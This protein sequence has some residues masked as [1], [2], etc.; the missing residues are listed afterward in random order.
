MASKKYVRNFLRWQL[1]LLLLMALLAYTLV[2]RSW[3]FSS[4]A[5][6]L[7]IVSVLLVLL[8][9]M[10]QTNLMLASFFG[11]VSSKDFSARLANNSNGLGFDELRAS[12]NK[13]NTE[14]HEMNEV[15]IK[16]K[17][18]FANVL[19]YL[20]VGVFLLDENQNISNPN[21]V[22]QH[23]LNVQGA[24]LYKS[25]AQRA[26]YLSHKLKELNDKGR[27][28]IEL[29]V[30][31]ESQRWSLSQQR[32][33]LGE[34]NYKVI[35][36]S[37]LQHD[38]ERKEAEV[39]E[40]LMHTLTHEIMNSVSP[41]TSLIDTLQWQLKRET[42]N[43]ATVQFSDE[44]FADIQKAVGTI[45]K[46]SNGLIDFV[47][48]YSLLSRLPILQME[49]IEVTSFFEELRVLLEPELVKK[50]TQ[51]EVD[52]SS[53]NIRFRGDKQLLFQVLINLVKNAVEAGNGNN[54]E[55][56]ITAAKGDGYTYLSVIDWA[57]GVPQEIQKDIFLPFFTTKT[58][59]SGIGLSLSR[60]IIQA[61]GGRLY[62]KL[63][64]LGSEFRIE[65]SN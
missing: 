64:D 28:T 37:N 24:S 29:L 65:L 26:P 60:K 9:K 62:L 42:K 12:L 61:H 11:G 8:Q 56:K 17:E 23:F 58:K 43:E 2:V 6:L 52:I 57:G 31:G 63:R 10:K 45:H 51:L 20:P 30:K 25:W 48:R 40:K 47:Q 54:Q 44:Q 53:Q 27:L 7:V 39:S 38:M 19:R 36:L 1:T 22:A 46:R 21:N 4:I 41:I 14:M 5:L 32:I 13:L 49:A 16:S 15:K 59:G 55:V 35:L 33:K 50:S 3:W 18:L 34:E